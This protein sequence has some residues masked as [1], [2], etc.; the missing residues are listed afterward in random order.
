M[1]HEFPKLQSALAATDRRTATTLIGIAVVALAYIAA[2]FFVATLPQLGVP[3][4]VIGGVIALG[5]LFWGIR[6]ALKAGQVA[7]HAH[8]IHVHTPEEFALLEKGLGQ[9]LETWGDFSFTPEFLIGPAF[10]PVPIG[11][12][13]WAYRHVVK[14]R[15]G[16]EKKSQMW[17]FLRTGE[18]E[19]FDASASD[20]E[21]AFDCLRERASGIRIGY[22]EYLLKKWKTE[23][24][25]TMT[26]VYDESV[27]ARC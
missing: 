20:I 15:N 13:A 3:M 26:R 24:E 22:D 14:D 2:Q 9:P 19:I 27:P 7:D 17:V 6:I 23:P 12:V 5:A 10:F 18:R 16:M 1:E 4:T 8:L 25:A 11:R 21:P